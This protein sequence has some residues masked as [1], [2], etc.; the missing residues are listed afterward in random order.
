MI[1]IS[2]IVFILVL[3]ECSKDPCI[4]GS[5]VTQIDGSAHCDC[6][7]GFKGQFCDGNAVFM[8]VASN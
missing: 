3:D 8:F 7:E 2:R 1:I 5:C 6:D 4:N